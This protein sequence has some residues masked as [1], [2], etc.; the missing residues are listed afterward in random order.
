MYH[1]VLD[2][3]SAEIPI[4]VVQRDDNQ[5]RKYTLHLDLLLPVGCTF[6]F[7]Y[8]SQTHPNSSQ[9]SKGKTRRKLNIDVLNPEGTEV[10]MMSSKSKPGFNS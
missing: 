3:Q 10:E 7:L 6:V 1:L 5:C 8:D 4:Y 9:I 2:Q